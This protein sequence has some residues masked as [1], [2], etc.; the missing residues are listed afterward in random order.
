[1]FQFYRENLTRHEALGTKAAARKQPSIICPIGAIK[2]AKSSQD[3]E[4]TQKN[5]R[6]K[7]GSQLCSS[8]KDIKN[9]L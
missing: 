6:Q 4:N 5:T 1:L 9:L 8:S 7:N 2:K 3:F